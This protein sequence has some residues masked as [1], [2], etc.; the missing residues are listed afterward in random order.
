MWR[1][2]VFLVKMETMIKNIIFDMGKV[3]V[4]YDPEDFLDKEKVF[5]KNDRVLL[6]QE[7]F[8]S[9]MWLQMDEGILNHKD[10]LEKV[11]ERVPE[12]LHSTCEALLSHWYDYLVPIE[13]MDELVMAM[14][15]KGYGIYLLSNAGT[16]QEIYWPRIRCSHSFDGVV[17]SAFEKCVKPDPKIYR[18]LLDRYELKAEECLFIDDVPINVQ[19]AERLRIKGHL[20]ID[21]EELKTF[22]QKEGI[23]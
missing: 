8:Y 7:I 17:V 3:L 11:K 2:F 23:L 18:I 10:M 22:L 12:R 13:G 21:T 4:G 14:K 15:E 1:F 19:A 6:L 16:Q 5:D 20:F 9:P